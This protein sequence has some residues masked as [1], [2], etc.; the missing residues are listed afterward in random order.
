MLRS[1]RLTAPSRPPRPPPTSTAST[2]TR[3]PSPRAPR[4][5]S[6]WRTTST[7]A[8]SAPRRP[9]PV[10]ERR[11]RGGVAA[12]FAGTAVDARV[13]EGDPYS[14]S[15]LKMVTP[16]GPRAPRRCSSRSRARRPS[17]AW[18]RAPRGVDRL[19]PE[20][21]ARLRNAPRPRRRARA[22]AGRARCARSRRRSRRR[23]GRTASTPRP[24]P[25]TS[26]VEQ[27]GRRA[28]EEDAAASDATS[29]GVVVDSVKVSDL[30]VGPRTQRV[31]GADG[32]LER[33]RHLLVG[34]RGGP[35]LDDAQALQRLGQ[36]ERAVD[37]LARVRRARVGDGQG[38]VTRG[39]R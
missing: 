17:S 36:R 8:S 25:C 39:S 9:A 6:P 15:A 13:L 34:G 26:V 38:R 24:P 20:L 12:L 29:Y 27:R 4:P 30:A 14:A 7:A 11:P 37:Q 18:P 35:R 28:S 33:D 31:V 5:R 16:P 19:Q 2:S 23:A 32:L 22:G 21:G 3:T 10:P 1:A